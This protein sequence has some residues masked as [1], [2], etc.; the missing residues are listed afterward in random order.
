MTWQGLQRLSWLALGLA[1]CGCATDAAVVNKTQPNPPA[2]QAGAAPPTPAG[3]AGAIVQTSAKE[4]T[5]N[6]VRAQK[7]EPAPVALTGEA[8]QAHPVAVICAAVNGHPIFDEEVRTAAGGALLQAPTQ[9]DY[10]KAFQASLKHIVARELVLQEAFAHLEKGGKQG[11]LIIDKLNEEADKSFEQGW[12]RAIMKSH[13]LHGRE[14]L[15]T[16]LEK[17]HVSLE[18]FRRIQTREWL[19]HQYLLSR[20]EPQMQQIGHRQIVAYYEGHPEEFR[21]AEAVD[22]QDLYVACS[23]HRSREDARR[24]ADHL[25]ARIQRGEDFQTL[26]REY[27]NGESRIRKGAGQ[28]HEHGEIDPPSLEEP[29]FGMKENEVRVIEMP[30]GFHIVRVVKHQKAGPMPFDADVQKKI[31]L[32]LK[33]EVW[34]NEMKRYVNALWVK[35]AIWPA[36]LTA[37]G[38]RDD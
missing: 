5:E 29:L 20:L 11:R 9:E 28:G 13:H 32:K 33:N 18:V 24:W 10:Q 2:S 23:A 3:P 27:D 30:S 4:A 7:P 21:L 26:S 38:S 15:K 14:E 36:N 37:P 12:M 8:A 35:S 6:P 1:A 34:K 22:W 17:E 25:A 16:L 31:N 19:F